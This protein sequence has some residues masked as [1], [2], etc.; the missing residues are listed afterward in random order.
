MMRRPVCSSL[1]LLAV[2]LGLLYSCRPELDYVDNTFRSDGAAL[3][4]SG[5]VW[6]G[7]GAV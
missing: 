1:I 5:G 3:K 4:G 7:P 6:G 2:L